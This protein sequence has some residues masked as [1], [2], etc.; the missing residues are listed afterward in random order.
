GLDVL[1]QLTLSQAG[2]RVIVLAAKIETE[3]LFTALQRGAKGIVLKNSSARDLVQAI[4]A[5]H[6]GRYW[7]GQEKVGDLVQGLDRSLLKKREKIESYGLTPRELQILP[8]IVEGCTNKDIAERFSITEDTVKRH[9]T[10]IFD[11]LGVSSR[12]E[13]GMFAI[14]HH[15]VDRT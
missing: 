3:Q 11:K 10:N 15:L 6:G 8:A 2:T 14:H 12:L 1:E 4:E 7:V 5:V 13:L 9:L